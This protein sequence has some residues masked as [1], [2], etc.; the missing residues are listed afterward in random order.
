MAMISPLPVRNGVNATRLRIPSAGEWETVCDYMLHRFG[1]VD[2]AGIVRR[3]ETG[4]VVGLGGVP[5]EL[6]TPLGEHEFIWYY[7]NLPVEAEIPFTESV[8]HHDEHLLVIDK[9]HFLPTTPGG[10]FIQQSALV[11]LRN[12]VGNPDLI[13]MHRLDRATAGVLLFSTNPETRGDYQTLF[14]RREISKTYEAVSALEDVDGRPAGEVMGVGGLGGRAEDRSGNF[15]PGAAGP[16]NSLLDSAG[17]EA[18]LEDL[19]LI[20]RNRM[21]KI[22][23]QLRS[24]VEAGEPNAESLVELLGVG[25]SAG[26]FAGLK[27][28]KFRLSPHSGKTHQLRVHLAALG[29]GILNDPFYPTLL[30]L[31][32]D[33]YTRPLQLL[34][35]SISFVDPISGEPVTYSSKLELSESPAAQAPGAPGLALG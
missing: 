25:P 31:A 17:L 27:V 11:R 35:R 18:A 19:P 5:I 33:D 28:A 16:G 15:I 30:D 6:S 26:N 22:K 13:P 32:P 4:E 29:L 2:E 14:E 1:H 20:Y 8:L 9:P 21:S 34:A 7:R 12:R 3:F 24:L 23:G 10:R